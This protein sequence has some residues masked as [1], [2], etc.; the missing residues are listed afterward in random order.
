MSYIR[1][2]IYNDTIIVVNIARV[3]WDIFIWTVFAILIYHG[4]S[5]WWLLLTWTLTVLP[6]MGKDD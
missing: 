3:V 4:M 1:D 2:N 6:S 5:P